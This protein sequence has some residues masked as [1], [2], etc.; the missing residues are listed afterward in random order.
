MKN[1]VNHKTIILPAC[2]TLK[3]KYFPTL[4][5]PDSSNSERFLVYIHS[6]RTM[7]FSSRN[8]LHQNTTLRKLHYFQAHTKVCKTTSYPPKSTCAIFISL[9]GE[10]WLTRSTHILLE[11]PS[12]T[13]KKQKK[14]NS[15]EIRQRKQLI[16]SSVYGVRKSLHILSA[17]RWLWW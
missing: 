17:D 15:Y 4:R 6:V 5:A 7:F 9:L 11:I 13:K 14:L 2:E 16:P 8:P 3:L 10:R 1:T 12:Q